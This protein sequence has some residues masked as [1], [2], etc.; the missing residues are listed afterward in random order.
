MNMRKLPLRGLVFA[1]AAALPVASAGAAM[2]CTTPGGHG[3]PVVTSY[4]PS[5]PPPPKCVPFAPK[6]EIYHGPNRPDRNWC[7]TWCAPKEYGRWV[8][9]SPRTWEWNV[10]PVSGKHPA[11]VCKPVFRTPPSGKGKGGRPGVEGGSPGVQ[12]GGLGGPGGPDIEN[13]APMKGQHTIG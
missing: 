12:G 9:E 6:D 1:A 7:I 5:P 2:A 10:V 4:R 3:G 11:P 8:Q 13:G